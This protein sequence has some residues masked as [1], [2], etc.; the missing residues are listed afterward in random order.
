[1]KNYQLVEC[2]VTWTAKEYEEIF[3]RLRAER[4]RFDARP[5]DP[6]ERSGLIDTLFQYLCWKHLGFLDMPDVTPDLEEGLFEVTD[7]FHG[8][9]W[10]EENL[11]RVARE[12][13]ELAGVSEDAS[14][15]DVIK[16]YAELMDPSNPEGE[17]SWHEELRAGIIFGGLL[18]KWDDVSHICS[19]LD[20]DVSVQYSAG[21]LIDQYFHYYLAVAGKLSGDWTDGMQKLLDSAKKCRQKRLREVIAAWE[22]AVAGDQAAFDKA[23]P[24]AVKSCSKRE[25][26]PSEFMALA[27]DETVIWLIAKRAGLTFPDMPDKLKAAVITRQS[28][29]LDS[30]P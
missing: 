23:F 21:T 28:V 6:G 22:A 30:E 24:A 15:E 10:S 9:W 2:W 7:Y 19:A 25:D 5:P 11:R 1:V 13:P 3:E 12:S 20:A 4:R 16:E 17:F 8:D 27:L 29:Q 14:I 18:E 26:D